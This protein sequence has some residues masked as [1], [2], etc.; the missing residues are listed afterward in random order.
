MSLYIKTI[1][2]GQVVVMVVHIFNP[3]IWEAK[4]GRCM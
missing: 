3:C 2:L 1:E 4:A